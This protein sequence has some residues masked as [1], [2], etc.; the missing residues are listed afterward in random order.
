M[1]NLPWGG[2]Y[3]K[4]LDKLALDFTE[5]IDV[6]E[7]MVQEDIWGSEAHAIMLG[8]KGII[9]DKETK[10]IIEGL[11]RIKKEIKKGKLKLSKELEDVHMNIETFLSKYIGEEIGGKLH[12][13][14]SRND[15]VL[16]DT[17]LYIRQ[18][19]LDIMT[20][21]IIFSE[22]LLNL[23]RKYVETIMPGYTHT[24]IAQPITLGFWLTGYVSMFLRD[25]ER[26]EQLYERINSNPLGACALSGTSFPID[27]EI[28]KRLLGF[29]TVHRHSFDVISSRDFII[30]TAS[31]LAILMSNLSRMSEDLIYWTTFE[32]QMMDVEDEFAT[33][34]SIMPQK[35]NLDIAELTRGRTGRVFGTLMNVL[36]IVKGTPGGYNRD[37]QEDKPALYNS[38]EIV[39]LTLIVF[40]EFVKNLRPNERRMEDLARSNFSTSTDLADYLSKEKKIP[41][42]K[43]HE[44][45]GRIV[46]QLIKRN[47]KDFENKQDL[48]DLLEKEGVEISL[49][50]LRKILE[51]M[52]AVNSKQS[53]G[54]TAPEEVEKTINALLETLEKDKE[55]VSLKGEEIKKSKS[56]IS[57]VIQ[58]I[59]EG[60]PVKDLDLDKFSIEFEKDKKQISLI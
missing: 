20:H 28:T 57:S 1:N 8:I 60:N 42:R 31:I 30:E 16:V 12:T 21:L 13:A 22:T 50:E 14:R 52:E 33:G 6:D 58:Y 36:T 35:K 23:S 37:F 17:K 55:F 40:N 7:K 5:S 45:V 11:E 4:S 15:Q 51:P 24:Q 2:R 44:I 19:L 49:K 53:S 10:K 32:F 27:R 25:L 48:K 34:S 26:F 59:I 47:Q 3:E 38:L 9:T 56:L 46:T 18:K 54:G 29:S 43:S 41:F 39:L